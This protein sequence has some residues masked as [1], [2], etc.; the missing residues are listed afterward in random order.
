MAGGE[1]VWNDLLARF[2]G[3]IRQDG[4]K[5]VNETQRCPARCWWAYYGNGS[6]IGMLELHRL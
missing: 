2:L 5:E 4:A 6:R 1:C 3:D